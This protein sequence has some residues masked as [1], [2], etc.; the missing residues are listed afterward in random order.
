MFL[1]V[2]DAKYLHAYKVQVSFNDGRVGVVDLSDALRGAVFEPLQDE[3]V[4]SQLT[5]DK[6]LDTISWPNGADLAPEYLYF[7]AFK[8]DPTLEEKFKEWGYMA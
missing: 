7:K 4:F 6:E 5:V 8:D 2:T 3:S 1:H